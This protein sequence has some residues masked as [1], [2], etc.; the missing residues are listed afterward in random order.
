M[1]KFLKADD[2]LANSLSAVAKSDKDV[3]AIVV[4]HNGEKN[5]FEITAEILHRYTFVPH[6]VCFDIGLWNVW[7]LRKKK[8]GITFKIGKAGQ[9]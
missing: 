5:F 4:S 9:Y 6:S 1:L 2:A 8:W 7:D 3:Q